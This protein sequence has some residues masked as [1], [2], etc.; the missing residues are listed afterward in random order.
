MKNF[1]NL[2]LFLH[3]FVLFENREMKPP[4]HFSLT[5]AIKQNLLGLNSKSYR[6][7]KYSEILLSQNMPQNA[8]FGVPDN[9]ENLEIINHLRLI[10]K[11]YLIKSRDTKK[12]GV[13]GLKKNII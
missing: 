6:T 13:E 11:Y 12:I 3:L 5:L 2:K 4:I 9:K 8:L 7:Q 1:L 10:I